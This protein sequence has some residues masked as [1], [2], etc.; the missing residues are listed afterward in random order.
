MINFTLDALRR[1]GFLLQNHSDQID[2]QA[3]FVEGIVV[4]YQKQLYE[5]SR[6]CFL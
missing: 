4:V 5:K 6:Y 2:H 1:S 3:S